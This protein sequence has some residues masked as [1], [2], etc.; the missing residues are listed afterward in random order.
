MLNCIYI[1]H[2]AHFT[3]V[4]SLV[5]EKMYAVYTVCGLLQLAVLLV[6]GARENTTENKCVSSYEQFLK[7][8]FNNSSE[9][10]YNLYQAIYPQ[11][12]HLS[13]VVYITYWV[14]PPNG[15][16]SKVT[17]KDSICPFIEW[18]WIS[19]PVFIFIT[20][21]TLN[22][23]TFYTLNYFRD[24]QT[25]SVDITVPYPCPKKA[26]EFLAL[27]TSLVSYIDHCSVRNFREM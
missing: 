24:W 12:G 2:I 1:V 11:N 22:Y 25:P 5:K 21:D 15:T 3:N 19:S 9:N 16:K 17:V 18:R 8:T 4:W 26:L 14:H 23:L 27:M 7:E 6:C 13:Y 10:R 20:P